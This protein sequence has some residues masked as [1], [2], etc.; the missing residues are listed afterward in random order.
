MTREAT[1]TK[2]SNVVS[3]RGLASDD[4]F[5]SSWNV[6]QMSAFCIHELLN[7]RPGVMILTASMAAVLMV[8]A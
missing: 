3:D 7:E 4:S 2:T 6:S 8:L 1:A 5:I